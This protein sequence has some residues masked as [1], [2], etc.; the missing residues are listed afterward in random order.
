MV[1]GF[2]AWAV[3][4][5]ETEKPARMAGFFFFYSISSEYHTGEINRP[6]IFEGIKM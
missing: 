4:S 2:A 5:G 3:S 1:A 6:N